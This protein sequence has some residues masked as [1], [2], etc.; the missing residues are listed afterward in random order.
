MGRSK[1]NMLPPKI[2]L[3][4]EKIYKQLTKASRALAE[5]K[6]ESKSIPNETILINTLGLQEAKDSSEIENI[7]TTQDELYRADVDET[8]DNSAAKEVKNY[9]LALKKGFELVK[10]HRLL[11]NNYILEI[12]K[13]I[14]PVRPGFR[15]VP[16]TVLK[17]TAGETI[18]EPPQ[19]ANEIIQFMTNLE[20]YIN[21]DEMH[22]VDPLVKMAIIHY[23]FESI[24]PFYDGNGRTGRIINI[25][26]LG[27]KELLDIPVL[28]LSRYIIQ[29]KMKYYRCLQAVRSNGDWEKWV[30]WLLKGIESTSIQTSALIRKIQ[31]MMDF[32]ET[33]IRKH[34]PKIYSKD[35]LENLFK[36]PYT[37]IKFLQEDLNISKPTAIQYLN[38]LIEIELLRKEKIWKTNFYINDN[39]FHLLAKDKS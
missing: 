39:L 13:I 1:L 30:V 31:N 21:E 17:N 11:T 35:L 18:Y 6:G 5:L 14:E 22:D 33:E 9:S 23:Q 38:K 28:Y 12:Q 20:K 4:T 26:Y 24:H 19:D 37:K 36:H 8:F 25:L 34:Y 32:F 3:H 16:G 15:K 27:Q 10:K 2:N 29:N 7:I